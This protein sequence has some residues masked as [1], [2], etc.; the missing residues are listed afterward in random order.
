[1]ETW[2][3]SEASENLQC[4]FVFNLLLSLSNLIRINLDMNTNNSIEN[5]YFRVLHIA[6]EQ[7]KVIFY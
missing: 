1:M 3:K 7:I 5:K 4:E 6:E 2:V